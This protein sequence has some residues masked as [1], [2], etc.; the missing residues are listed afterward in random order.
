MEN[1]HFKHTAKLRRKQPTTLHL[2]ARFSIGILPLICLLTIKS[3]LSNIL[4]KDISIPISVYSLAI[5]LLFINTFFLW[6]F[7]K[8]SPIKTLKIRSILQQVI[9]VNNFYYENKESGYITHSMI[10]KFYFVRNELHIEVHPNGGKYS[11]K[12]NNLTQI[13]QTA[14]NLNVI[15]IQDDYASHTTYILK[16]STNNYIE[17]TDWS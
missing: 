6:I 3:T 2:L 11:A 17:V 9:E 14:L 16:D 4:S 13:L 10:M 7:S 15:S 8:R 5:A 1:I 12:M